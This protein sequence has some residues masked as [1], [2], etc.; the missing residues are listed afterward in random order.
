[1]ARSSSRDLKIALTILPL[2][3]RTGMSPPYA[4]SVPGS[5]RISACTRQMNT[6]QIA[7]P[8]DANYRHDPARG[9][10]VLLSPRVGGCLRWPRICQP[11]HLRL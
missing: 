2:T 1:V 5:L 7:T 4:R 3:E 6:G 11:K 9:Q 8:L 10:T